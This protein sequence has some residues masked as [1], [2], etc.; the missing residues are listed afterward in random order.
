M[1]DPTPSF[2]FPTIHLNGSGRALLTQGYSN[3]LRT[4]QAARSALAEVECHPRDY[5]VDPD[6]KAYETA[7]FVRDQHLA[8]LDALIRYCEAHLI[9]FGRVSVTLYH[10][11]VAGPTPYWV[12]WNANTNLPCFTFCRPPGMS[13]ED[14]QRL[15]DAADIACGGTLSIVPYIAP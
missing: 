4:A 8:H 15:K 1:P 2:P 6:P 14:A 5:Y 10:V 3:A 12:T 9:S 11:S 7:R 13:L